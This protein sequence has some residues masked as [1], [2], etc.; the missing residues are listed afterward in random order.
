[1]LGDVLRGRDIFDFDQLSLIYELARVV[2][3]ERVTSF[4]THLL[5]LLQFEINERLPGGGSMPNDSG[6]IGDKF[7]EEEDFI[8]LKHGSFLI[9]ELPM[10]I[11]RNEHTEGERVDHSLNVC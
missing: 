3:I 2:K 6:H 5:F 11:L 1:M 10:N 9:I 7:V 4:F 8:S